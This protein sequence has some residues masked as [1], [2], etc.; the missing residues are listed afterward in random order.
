[1]SKI[2]RAIVAFILLS[3]F[4]GCRQSESTAVTRY[5]R[6]KR[7]DFNRRAAEK[8]LPLF[9]REDANRDGALQS[10]E[11]AVLWGF[12]DSEP[13]NWVNGGQFTPRFKSTY[14]SMLQP[15]AEPSSPDE[16]DRRRLVLEELAQ[17]KPTLVKTTFKDDSP[18]DVNMV[19]HVM[20]A[21]A[22]IAM[23]CK[24]R[25]MIIDGDIDLNQ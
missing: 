1:M 22:A 18:A 12:G 20:N 8:F 25:S 23:R 16:K 6:L 19:R 14:D 13:K 15:D 3:G 5:D 17:G 11:L 10:D 21:A 24:T 4:L 2:S 7:D 9:W